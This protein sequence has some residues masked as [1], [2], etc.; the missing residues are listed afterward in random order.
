MTT[1]KS[2]VTS[3][4]VAVLVFV[5]GWAIVKP[6]SVGSTTEALGAGAAQVQQTI[7]QF[8]SGISLDQSSGSGSSGTVEFT[9][10]GTIGPGQNQGVWTNKTGRTVYIDYGDIALTGSG[11]ASSSM[12]VSGVAT[13]SSSL[14]TS[15][16]YTAPVQTASSTLLVDNRP[17]ATSS[18][19][20]LL[21]INSDTNQGANA[22]GT[23][24]VLDGSSFIWQ[25]RQDSAVV[26]T[27]SVC[28]QATSTNR[29]FNLDWY[30]HG[31]YRP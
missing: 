22:T 15:M 2:I 10:S 30:I 14:P 18:P 23:V 5:A 25:L 11:F 8:A 26:C 13:T 7:W 3:L 4:V 17:I 16:A 20:R 29:G 21:V 19:G 31:H 27:G 12:R 24:A 28:E 1:V 6:A 9:K